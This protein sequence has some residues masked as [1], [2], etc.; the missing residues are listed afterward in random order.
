M[1]RRVITI[2]LAALKLYAYIHVLGHKRSLN[3]H[4]S[5]RNDSSTQKRSKVV[6]E[7]A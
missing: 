3:I 7:V 6:L 5:E 4:W 1:Q 2:C